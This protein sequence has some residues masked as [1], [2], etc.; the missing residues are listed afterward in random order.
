MIRNKTTK[1]VLDFARMVSKESLKDNEL[2]WKVRGRGK[3]LFSQDVVK[4]LHAGF[5]PYVCA[6]CGK[7][8]FLPLSELKKLCLLSES[9][10][11]NNEFKGLCPECTRKWLEKQKELGLF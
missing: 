9:D 7:E 6:E 11:K 4:L 3:S 5:K 1:E 8:L 2:L 10:L